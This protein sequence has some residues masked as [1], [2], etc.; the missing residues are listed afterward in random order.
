MHEE[1]DFKALEKTLPQEA[2]E[3]SDTYYLLESLASEE[4]FGD[5]INQNLNTKYHLIEIPK[6]R[7]NKRHKSPKLRESQILPNNVVLKNLQLTLLQDIKLDTWQWNTSFTVNRV[8]YKFEANHEYFTKQEDNVDQQQ[9]YEAS[10]GLH[11]LHS[12]LLASGIKTGASPEKWEKSFSIP[13]VTEKFVELL[14]IN[15]EKRTESETTSFTGVVSHPD[16]FNFI[17]SSKRR[18]D[19]FGLNTDVCLDILLPLK[20]TNDNKKWT[21]LYQFRT[22]WNQNEPGPKTSIVTR[23][24]LEGLLDDLADDLELS[25][26]TQDKSKVCEIDPVLNFSEWKSIMRLADQAIDYIVDNTKLN[27]DCFDTTD[28]SA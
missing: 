27:D 28:T 11:F 25:Q 1:L 5:F 22:L 14:A 24:I 16:D 20:S 15:L 7:I 21:L 26:I 19:D 23:Q 3:A 8:P 12:V 13:E 6:L 17:A 4:I 10:T 2:I 18:V 9:K